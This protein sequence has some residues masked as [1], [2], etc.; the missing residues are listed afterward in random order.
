MVQM[1]S[2]HIAAVMTAEAGRGHCN[3]LDI[4]TGRPNYHLSGFTKG[5]GNLDLCTAGTLQECRSLRDLYYTRIHW[6]SLES[7]D[8]ILVSQEF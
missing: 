6:N 2:H 4:I 3:T 5:G 7:L 8:D 1:I